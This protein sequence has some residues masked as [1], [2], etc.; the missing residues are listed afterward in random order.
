MFL[1]CGYSLQGKPKGVD[2]KCDFCCIQLIAFI[3]LDCEYEKNEK[4][5]EAESLLVTLV[6]HRP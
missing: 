6:A 2:H 5:Q 4:N 3:V 1:H